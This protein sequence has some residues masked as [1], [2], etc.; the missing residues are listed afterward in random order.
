[1]NHNLTQKN[2]TSPN[3]RAIGGFLEATVRACQVQDL[4]DL[5][6][7]L[8]QPL[9][10]A[11]GV[12]RSS[13]PDL[14]AVQRHPAHIH[15]PPLS[16]GRQHL[17]EQRLHHIIDHHP[18]P[19]DGGM[20]RDHPP[21]DR[22]IR[23]ITATRRLQLPSRPSPLAI[24]EHQQRQ[25][26]RRIKRRTAPLAYVVAVAGIDSRQVQT[27]HHPNHR[28]H[29]TVVAQQ[30]PIRRHPQKRLITIRNQKLR[31]HTPPSHKP[32]AIASTPTG[33]AT[34]P[35]GEHSNRSR[36]APPGGSIQT[37]PATLPQGGA[38]KPSLTPTRILHQPQAPVGSPRTRGRRGPVPIARNQSTLIERSV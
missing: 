33:I 1:M 15:Q 13:R 38:F 26:H 19:G 7:K 16:T 3:E 34:L 10:A 12:F 37:D 2:L 22:L 23:H 24:P 29:Q 8:G 4:S 5:D 25:H 14:G 20:I 32:L 35:E 11:V 28:P 36:G 21:T 27:L 6:L 17:H 30:I 9:D 31:S 18:E